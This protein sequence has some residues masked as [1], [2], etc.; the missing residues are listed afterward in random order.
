[1]CERVLALKAHN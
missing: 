1:M